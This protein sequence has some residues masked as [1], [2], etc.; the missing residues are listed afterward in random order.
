MPVNG[1]RALDVIHPSSMDAFLDQLQRVR[2]IISLSGLTVLLG[3]GGLSGFDALT[4]Y[5]V[6]LGVTAAHAIWS[7]ARGLRSP[8]SMLA[9]DTTV[10]GAIMV[11][12]DAPRLET[13]SLAVLF[14]LVSL[15]AHGH[16]RVGFLVYSAGWYATSYFLK[17]EFGVGS[18]GELFGILLIIGGVAVIIGRVRGWLGRL[19]ADRSQMLGTVSHELRNNL[20]GMLG[21]TEIVSMDEEMGA[22]EARE[23]VA[24]AHQQAVDAGEIIED[25]LTATRLESSVLTVAAERVDVNRE[26]E[27]VVRRVSDEGTVL[28]LATQEDLPAADADAL[29]VRQVVRK[30][31]SNAVRY[32]G[33]AIRVVTSGSD[34]AIKIVV[35]DDG[36][37]VPPE[38]EKTIFLPYRRSTRSSHA[39]SVGLGLWIS[40]QLAEA[41]G[42]TLE[43]RRV[44]GWTEFV[45][46]LAVHT[47][48]PAKPRRGRPTFQPVG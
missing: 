14:V 46:T 42:G 12:V 39:S 32:G 13:A 17:G 34:R 44:D 10:W 40:R 36:G 5:L 16:W 7:L 1:P 29:R 6:G 8:M 30:L 25:L 45:L 11:L 23:L 48:E 35:A 2:L 22:A 43:Y 27:T 41:M 20:T 24:M 33:E 47:G 19:E 37:G 38:D 4:P 31:L 21:L 15:F 9:I 26:V 18:A 3:L 28:S